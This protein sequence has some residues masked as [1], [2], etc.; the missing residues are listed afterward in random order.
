MALFLRDQL[1]LWTQRLLE[2]VG[3]GLPEAAQ[4]AEILCAADAQGV[5]SHGL[6]RL[7]EYVPAL[8]SGA[9]R[10]TAHLTVVTESPAT[11]VV[12]GGSGIG[13][14][15]ALRAMELCTDKAARHGVAVVTLRNGGH[16]GRAAYYAELAAR[17]Q[18]VGVAMTN[19]SPCIAPWGG[20]ERVLG[21]NPVAI[22]VPRKEHPPIVL[23]MA[24][25]V[26]AQ[27]RIRLARDRG[28]AI[29]EGWGLDPEGRPT[30]DPRKVL[31]GSLLPIA[32][33]KGYGLALV[34]DLLTGVLSGGAFGREVTS[35]RD[36]RTQNI[37]HT[38]AAIHIPHFRE[39]QEFYADVER[40]VGM[41]KASALAPGY[42]EIL[43]PG[44][45][46][47]RHEASRAGHVELPD[48]ICRRVERVA[49][50]LGFLEPLPYAPDVPQR[51]A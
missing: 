7:E 3:L 33:Y 20:R 16:F 8:R 50:G 42:G 41:V 25:S 28:E 22:A 35:A 37:S 4:L 17:R 14:L 45:P 21:N 32:G 23:D 9:W 2:G 18:M 12:D 11:A 27:G 19:S 48:D 13:P 15:L 51:G 44:E 47:Q 49:Q 46:E 34:V 1:A 6:I 36:L 29:P 26:V 31:E 38:F 43:L 24:L 10:P 40:L 39:L 5:H 30:R